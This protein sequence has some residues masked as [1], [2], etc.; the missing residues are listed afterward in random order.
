MMKQIGSK[1]EEQFNALKEQNKDKTI[2][3][4]DVEFDKNDKREHSGDRN[5]GK[6]YKKIN[7]KR[8]NK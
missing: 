3:I 4:P 2:E 5:G 1:R 8:N 7:K 6:S